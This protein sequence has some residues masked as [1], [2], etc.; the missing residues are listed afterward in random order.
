MRRGRGRPGWW[1]R[2]ACRDPAAQASTTSACASPTSTTRRARWTR[3]SSASPCATSDADARDPRLRLRAV[4]ARAR[5]R[6]RRPDA[7]VRRTGRGELRR[8]V[9]LD[10]AA[11]APRRARRR[12]RRRAPTRCTWPI[13]RAR[14]RAVPFV[15]AD[16]RRP[17]IARQT[18]TLPGL[19]PAQARPRQPLTGDMARRRRRSTPTCSAWRSPTT[20]ATPARGCTQ[21][22]PPRRSRWST[23]ARALP[24]P[25][26]SSYYD[27]GELRVAVRPPRPARPLAVLGPGAPRHRAEHLRL[28]A[29]PRGAVHVE[30]LRRHGAARGRA[31]AAP[32]ARR[33]LLVQHLGPPAAAVVLPLRRRCR[34]S[35]SARASRPAAS[36]SHPC[37]RPDLGDERSTHHRRPHRASSSS[38]ASRGD[39]REIWLNGEKVT[40]PLEHPGARGRGALD[41]ARLRPAARARRRDARARPRRPASSS[42]SRTSSRARSTTCT[43]RR[44]AF[45]LIGLVDRRH[46]GPHARLPQRHVRVL[47]GRVRACGPAAAT[48]RAP[49]TSSP[50]TSCM[51]DRDLSTTHSI[52]NPQ[53]DRS[54]PEAE[55]AAGEVALHK[56]GETDTRIVVRGARM[57]ATLG[58]VRRRAERLPGLGH[59]PAGRQLRARLRGADG[60]ARPEADLPRLVRHAAVALRLPAVVA[61]R[62]DGLPS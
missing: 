26:A 37:R 17:A 24:P 3:C 49:R 7:R 45:E 53:V 11:R 28:R 14:H 44:R 62:R 42:T 22:R 51:R 1:R 32:L 12:L 15:H 35:P 39:A 60:H 47:R 8:S 21:R 57:L 30:L 29:H 46:D 55:Q 50:T 23:R 41:R 10:D 61:L 43:R 34:S 38:T 18:T 9:S 56:V 16:D 6:R 58:P 31:R 13:P 20:S 52:M 4:L 27:C 40:H 2:G 33:P 19:P 48:S 5:A 59:P 36:R 25:R 54:K